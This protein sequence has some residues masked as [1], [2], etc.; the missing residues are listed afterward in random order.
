VGDPTPLRHNREF[1]ALWIGQTVSWLGISISSFAYPLVVLE[2]TGSAARAGLV[3]SVLT[4]TTF[5]LRLPGGALVDRWNRKWI[6]IVCDLGR[7]AASGALALV[8]ALGHFLLAQILLVAFLE[9]AFGVLFG[10]AESAAVRRVV[11]PTQLRDAVAKNQGRSQTAGLVGPPLGGVLLEVSRALPFAADAASYLASLVSVLFVRSS[12]QDPR[13]ASEPRAGLRGIFDGL[14]WLWT[15]PVLR[16]LLL[17]MAFGGVVSGAIGLVLIVLARGRGAS[18]SQLGLMFAMASAGGV[19]GAFAAPRLLRRLEPRTLV[20][21]EAW[22]VALATLLLFPV[23]S[24]YLI[25]LLG[26]AAFFLA[27]SVNAFVFASIA[28]SCP[29]RLLGRAN[30]AAI[31]LVSLLSPLSPLLAGALLSWVGAPT[32]VLIYAGALGV[33]A[34]VATFMPGLRA[35]AGPPGR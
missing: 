26:A 9:G 24:P 6:M 5:L 25:G 4:A 35:P 19:L 12:L 18:S 31:Q 2:A 21:A 29:D 11:P 22:T 34:V 33:L 17:W 20:A 15:R 1:R 16:P 8:L 23:H 27:P 7:A 3:G 28:E 32:T 30:G 13:D 10:P 14:R